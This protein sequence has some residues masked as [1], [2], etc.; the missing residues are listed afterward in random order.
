MKSIELPCLDS[1]VKCAA[2]E[3]IQSKKVIGIYATGWPYQNVDVLWRLRQ[4]L[5][6]KQCPVIFFFKTSARPLMDSIIKA[7]HIIDIQDIYELNDPKFFIF[8]DFIDVLVTSEVV[9]RCH[10]AHFIKAKLVSISFNAKISSPSIYNYYFDYTVD[11]INQLQYCIDSHKIDY[12]FYPDTCKIHRNHYFTKL[13]LGHLKIDLLVEE[14]MKYERMKSSLDFKSHVFLIYPTYTTFSTSLQKIGH[15]KY[16]EI[17]KEIILAYLAWQKDGIVVLRPK[18]VDFE[19]KL[20]PEFLALKNAFENT[21][22]FFIDDEDDNKF[23]ICRADYF[24]TDYSL[25]YINFSISSKKPSIRLVYS[26]KEEQPK[27]DQ[28]GWIISSSR[29]L[30]PLLEEMNRD[31]KVWRKNLLLIQQREIPTLGKN[32]ALFADMLKSI[33]SNDDNPAW[34]KI[35]KGHTSLHTHKDVLNLVAKTIKNS[36]FD[37]WC[38]HIWLNDLLSAIGTLTPPQ[39]W[40]LLL[41][42]ALLP[43]LALDPISEI[44]FFVDN[45]ISNALE[46]LPFIEIVSTLSDCMRTDSKLTATTLLITI[47]S[48]SISAILRNKC[49]FFLLVEWPQGDDDV[50]AR[51]NDLA[52]KMPQHFSHPVLNKLNLFLPLAMKLPL[53]MRRIAIP[54]LGFKNPLAKNYWQARRSLG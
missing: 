17:W 34:F 16:I 24:I 5:L 27:L 25:A 6:I 54:I 37:L 47:S 9:V 46:S 32:F 50:Y 7:S 3:Q 49:L 10:E 44:I 36:G 33:F 31:K 43:Q 14:R 20:L 19:K 51:V 42:R 48:K 1:H 21:G 28:W 45:C 2:L 12:D 22:R 4:E 41:K 52:E 40:L 39:I 18:P 13:I 23:W 11:E 26:W 38:L 35:E 30:I 8:F 29:Q 53:F 15:E